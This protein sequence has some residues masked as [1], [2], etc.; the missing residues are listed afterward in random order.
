MLHTGVVHLP[1]TAKVS[2]NLTGLFAT[3]CTNIKVGQY[4]KEG[5]LHSHIIQIGDLSVISFTC[6]T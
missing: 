4:Q 1:T 3:Q 2:R 5:N 6:H